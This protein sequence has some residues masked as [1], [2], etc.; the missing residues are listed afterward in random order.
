MKLNKLKKKFK[1]NAKNHHINFETCEVPHGNVSSI[2]YK[3]NNK[4]IYISDLSDIKK[5]DYQFFYNI[6]TLVID[7]LWFRDYS[8]HH[9]NFKRTMN[10][11][12]IFNP[13]KTVLTNL[14][15]DLDYDELKSLVPKNVIPAYDGMKLEL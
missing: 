6:K 12:K 5:K 14:H 2:C 11:I 1:I 8:S 15:S 13:N 3:I 10:F 9:L 4:L 7:C